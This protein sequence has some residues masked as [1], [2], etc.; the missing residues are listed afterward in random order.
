MNALTPGASAPTIFTFQNGRP[1]PVRIYTDAAGDP[2]FHAGDLCALLEHGN[3]HQALRTHV[4]KDD[5]QKMEV[6]DRLGRTQQ[7]NFVREPGMWSLL[8]GSHAPNAKKVK[9]WITAEVLP[10]IRK[11]G[12]Y[13][14]EAVPEAAPETLSPADQSKLKRLVWLIAYAY[15][16]ENGV[17]QAIYRRLRKLTGTPAP[18]VWRVAD[19]PLIA[20]ELTRL[21]AESNAYADA[22]IAFEKAVI[23]RIAGG[24]PTSDMIASLLEDG[25]DYAAR[26]DAL[27]PVLSA[28]QTREIATLT[29]RQALPQPQGGEA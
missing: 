8:L 25:N 6:I 2:L 21:F 7:A 17:T 22:R 19:L 29:Q 26:M 3:P 9:R 1:H 4:E 24:E 5:L 11:T 12:R 20:A 28:W 23:R 27:R 15:R 18:Q 13:V 16:H 10:A 14:A